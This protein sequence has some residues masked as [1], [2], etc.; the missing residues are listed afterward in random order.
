MCVCASEVD[1]LVELRG[2]ESLQKLPAVREHEKGKADREGETD[3]Q[4]DRQ[5]DKDKH[6]HTHTH[7]ELAFG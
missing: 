6:T 3:R 4:T 1:V 7:T 2:G 5:T